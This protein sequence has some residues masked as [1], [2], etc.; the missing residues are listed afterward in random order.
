M[1]RQK[2]AGTVWLHLKHSNFAGAG[3]STNI[4]RI[5][6]LGQ[7]GRLFSVPMSQIGVVANGLACP[8]VLLS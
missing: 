6:H 5:S 7:C 2:S 1:M 3:R 4:M 8:N